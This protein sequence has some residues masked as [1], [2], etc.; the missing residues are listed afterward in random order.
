MFGLDQGILLWILSFVIFGMLVL[1]SPIFLCVSFWAVGASLITGFTL[2][3]IGITCYQGI[4]SYALLA[5][6][7]FI[8]TGDLLGEAGVAAKLANLSKVAMCRIRGGMALAVQIATTVFSAVSGS[9]SAT[10]ATIGKIMIPEM[11]KEGYPRSYAAT[12]TAA[13]GITGIMVPPSILMI[14]YAF[15]T[16]TSVL[17]LFMAGILPGIIMTLFLMVASYYTSSKNKWGVLSP[18]SAKATAVALA[19]AHYGVWA[20]VLILVIVYNGIASPTEA[21]GVISAY[22]FLVGVFATRGIK[23]QRIPAIFLSSGRVCGMLAPVI[24][25][26]IVLQ[27]NFAIIGVHRMVEAFL[28][29]FTNKWVVVGIMMIMIT[30]LGAIMESISMTIVLAPILAPIALDLGFN[31][32]HFGIVFVTGLCIGFITPPFGLDLF[33]ASGITGEPYGKLIRWLPAYL[34]V[35]YIHWL[36]MTLFPGICLSTVTSPF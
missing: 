27:Q 10:V 2:E 13:G 33:V 19:K 34:I 14:V 32:I 3:N 21:A 12:T 35:L 26:S 25:A 18:F 29:A 5:M 6:P 11:E 28:L 31:P 17:D 23:L 36:L 24:A 4:S 1:G 7:L 22:G 20:I 15:S 30:L 8:L 16:N 9:N